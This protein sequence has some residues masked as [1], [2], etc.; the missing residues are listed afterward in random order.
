MLILGAGLTVLYLLLFA[1][2]RERWWVQGTM[3]GTITAL[4]VSSLLVIHFLDHPF[5]QD[6]AYIPPDE[7]ATTLRLIENEVSGNSSILPPC[8]EHGRPG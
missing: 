1:D 2:R 4:V 6:G 3:I 8:D 5:N 7:M